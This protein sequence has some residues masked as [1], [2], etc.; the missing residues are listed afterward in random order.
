MS[1]EPYE[2]VFD[3]RHGRAVR[4]VSTPESVSISIDGKEVWKSED[5][6]HTLNTP[7]RMV[8]QPSSPSL[9]DPYELLTVE[10]RKKLNAD[11]V[12]CA[13]DSLHKSSD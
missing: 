1:G 8:H 11:L 5:V 2:A 10:E 13:V 3:D 6:S 9:R 7:M 12:C 4:I